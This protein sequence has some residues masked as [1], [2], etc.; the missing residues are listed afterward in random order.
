MQLS[1]LS[2]VAV[3]GESSV[4]PYHGSARPVLD[5]AG[6]LGADA[7]VRGGSAHRR[8]GAAPGR[9]IRRARKRRVWTREYRGADS[10]VLALQRRATEG[11]VGALDLDLPKRERAA[12]RGAPM[13]DRGSVRPLS[14]REGGGDRR[15]RSRSRSAA[16]RESLQRAQS[17]FARARERDPD[18][19]AARARLALSHLALG[20]YDR[21]SR[22]PNRPARGGGRAAARARTAEAHEAL[23]SYWSLRGER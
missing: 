21:T 9:A 4:L 20:R 12:L 13:A 18:F 15:G 23:A 1:R 16:G 5:I 7:V 22:G 6:E 19:A 14:P 3:T 8:P 17:F 11:I 10:T 2:A